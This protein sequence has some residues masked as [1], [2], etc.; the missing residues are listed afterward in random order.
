VA[1]QQP[2]EQEEDAQEVCIDV[3]IGPP[4]F[5][6]FCGF[7]PYVLFKSYVYTRVHGVTA[8]KLHTV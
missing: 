5:S 1:A 2:A 3:T 8:R 4:P 7:I 6:R